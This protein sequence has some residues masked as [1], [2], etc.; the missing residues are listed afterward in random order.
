MDD[1]VWLRHS[2]GVGGSWSGWTRIGGVITAAPAATGVGAQLQLVARGSDNAA[3]ACRI[4]SGPC[5]GWEPMGGVLGSGPAVAPWGSGIAAYVVG[6]D[7]RL[8]QN[9]GGHTGWAGWHRLP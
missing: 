9:P 3:W 5:P 1:A 8:Y 2:V 6:T 7:G 4:T